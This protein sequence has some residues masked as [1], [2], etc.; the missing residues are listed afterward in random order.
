[1]IV[2]KVQSRAR[3]AGAANARSPRRSL[4]L[5]AG[6]L[7]G[8]V[9]L[10]A[11][12]AGQVHAA[13]VR[14]SAEAKPGLS[15]TQ[16]RQQAL[17][18]A[19]LDAVM[20]ET[21]R[22]VPATTPAARLT[23]L[24]ADLAP[25]VIDYIQSYQDIIATP[26]QNATAQTGDAANAT[27]P[28]PEVEAAPTEASASVPAAPITP[29]TSGATG[30]PFV[31]DVNVL[32]AALRSQLTRLGFLAGDKHPGTYALRLGKGVRERDLAALA[33]ED[34]LLGLR[35]ERPA[36]KSGQAAAR[37]EVGMERRSRGGYTAVLR[38]GDMVV[39]ADGRTIPALWRNLWGAY[40]TDSRTQ[41][42]P[43]ERSLTISGFPGVDAV[44]N[45]VV[46]LSG[47]DDAVLDP[48]LSGMDL[49]ETGVR[50]RFS[51]RVVNQRALD[52][53][54]R[55]ALA[56]GKL[57]LEGQTAPGADSAGPATTGSAAAP[58]APAATAYGPDPFKPAAPSALP[59]PSAPAAPQNTPGVPAP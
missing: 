38:Q 9:I 26:Q 43:G 31:F 37:V 12:L 33:R 56:E 53:H 55:Q 35:R 21:G 19:L 40:F 7:L 32:R 50:A 4:A 51:C 16:A 17:G 45:F 11:P 20:R 57:T 23:A 58:A 44:R 49:A 36:G 15:P 13:S 42:G 1:M 52:A 2:V 25:R 3:A 5:A 41:P 48:A 39:N 30:G 28:A 24:R 47:W 46:L 6:L 14:V 27:E 18:Q 54:L 59:A 10:A 34:E 22:L 8:A 29:I